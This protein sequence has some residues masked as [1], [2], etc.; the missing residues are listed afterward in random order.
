MG[1]DGRRERMVTGG[2][3]SKTLNNR[4]FVNKLGI[5]F[6]KNA[7]KLFMNGFSTA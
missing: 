2:A 3:S 1:K 6:I 5:A 7:N 4:I